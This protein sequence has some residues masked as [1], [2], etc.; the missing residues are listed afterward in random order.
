MFYDIIKIKKRIKMDNNLFWLNKNPYEA[1]VQYIIEKDLFSEKN[2]ELSLEETIFKKWFPS[3]YCEVIKITPEKD[4]PFI[5]RKDFFAEI[6]FDRVGIFIN[7]VLVVTFNNQ[8]VKR[9]NI[10]KEQYKIDL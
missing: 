4:K 9:I 1:L 10:T 2:I 5:K 7:L 6:F 8:S 3:E